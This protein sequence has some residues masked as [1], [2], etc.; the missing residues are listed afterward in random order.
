M[1]V[2][3]LMLAHLL[4]TLARLLGPGGAEASEDGM[5]GCG[6]KREILRPRTTHHVDACHCHFS[7]WFWRVFMRFSAGKGGRSGR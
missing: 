3:L 7:V 2:L 6:R 4:A 1:K 5:N